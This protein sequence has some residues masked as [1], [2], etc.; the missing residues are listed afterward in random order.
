MAIDQ[1]IQRKVDAY[2]NNPAALQQRYQQNQQ[3]IDLL[4]LQKLKSEKDAAAKE[5]QMQMEQN[6]QTIKQQRERELLDRTKQDMM[7]QQAG[8]MQ[9]AQQRQQKNMQQVAKQGAAS[10]QQMQQVQRGLGSLAGQIRPQVARMAAGGIVAFQTGGGVTQ[11]MIEAYRRQGGQGRRARASMTDDEIRAILQARMGDDGGVPEGYERVLTR[12][13][14]RTRPIQTA[15]LQ[16]TLADQAAG[17]DGATG[18]QGA[19]PEAVPPTAERETTTAVV[20]TEGGVADG[21]PVTDTEMA[22]V[23]TTTRGP[24]DGLRGGPAAQDAPAEGGGLPTISTPSLRTPD[25][26]GGAA[27]GILNRFGIGGAN[28]GGAGSALNRARDDAAAFMGRD[29]KRERFDR[30]IGRLE[31]FDARYSDPDRQR[32]E[33][34]SAFLRG[35]AGGGSFGTTMAGGSAG[36]AAEREKQYTNA[37]QRLQDIIGLN[38]TAINVDTTIAGQAQRSGDAAANRA[39]ANARQAADIASRMSI[40]EMNQAYREADLRLRAEQGNL[41]AYIQEQEIAANRDLKLA[42]EAQGNE[43]ATM[44]LLERN[45]AR[46]AEIMDRVMNDVE[47]LGLMRKAEQSGDP[48]DVA[49]AQ[50][51]QDQLILTANIIMNRAGLFDVERM[52]YERL[53]MPYNRPSGAGAGGDGGQ[54]DADVQALLERYGS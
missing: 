49:A 44:T 51:K 22:A 52:L 40:A 36:M 48:A 5:M 21:V 37:R 39:A 25:A 53:G 28:A 38:E 19:S 23:E 20:D 24:D 45:T 17:Q 31:E 26:Q 7:Q 46:Q 16:A 43:Q 41:N 6:P 29:E 32:D 4:A 47:Y 30:L 14:T 11:E 9:M 3:L 34:I 50:R 18:P 13:G 1:E 15:E 8:I 27:D 2:R 33:Q 42:I 10:P 12:R 54:L 35:T